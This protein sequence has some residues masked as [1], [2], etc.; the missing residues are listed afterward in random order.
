MII[1]SKSDQPPLL[2]ATYRLRKADVENE[3]LRRKVVRL[4]TERD[5]WEEKHAVSLCDN[6]SV[7]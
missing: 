7:V 2:L 3:D 6:E 4:E 1:I 5:E